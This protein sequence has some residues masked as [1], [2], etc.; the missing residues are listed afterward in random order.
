MHHCCFNCRCATPPR[1]IHAICALVEFIYLAQN[2]VHSAETLL[3]MTQALADFH[4]F[5]Y[6]VVKAQARRGKKGAKED[7]FIPKLKLLQSFR[8]T[9]KRL[10]TLM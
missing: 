10:G 1:F 4:A 5:K 7:F 9:V 3:S 2:L 8:G 6:A